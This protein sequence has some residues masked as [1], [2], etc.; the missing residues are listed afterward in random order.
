MK[1]TDD[2][3][4]D[5]TNLLILQ[6]EVDDDD[7]FTPLTDV[8]LTQEQEEELDGLD[9]PIQD[10]ELFLKED[11]QVD[12]E[13]NISPLK[14]RKSHLDQSYCDQQQLNASLSFLQPNVDDFDDDCVLRSEVDHLLRSINMVAQ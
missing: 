4:D 10:F 12:E 5:E 2:V 3:L 14:K 11:E 7:G 1:K 8:V 9:E 6:P 13:I